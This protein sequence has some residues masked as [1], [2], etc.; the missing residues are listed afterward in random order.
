MKNMKHLLLGL[1]F[2]S[3][4]FSQAQVSVNVNIGSP[5]AWG[6]A[7]YTDVRY[8]YLPDID[9]YYDVNTTQYIYINNGAWVRAS[10]LPPAYRSYNLYNGY[11]VV[12][13]DYR[14]TTPYVY[15]KEHKVKYPKGYKGKPQ[16]N[17]GV[18]PGQAKKSG[19][20]KSNGHENGNKGGGN[21]KGHG[22]GKH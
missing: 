16:K 20:A 3:C 9:T 2:F 18:P 8:Y 4:A 1:L 6:P 19:P 14:G 12:V 22:K 7:G 17:I 13:N 5:P 11:K 10:A 15:Y 21:G